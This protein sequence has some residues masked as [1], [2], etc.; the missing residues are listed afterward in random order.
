MKHSLFLLFVLS[1]L[2]PGKMFAQSQSQSQSTKLVVRAKAKDA[3]F[4]GT[5]M[6]GAM[7]VVRDTE[8]GEILAQGVTEGS[9]GDTGRLMDTPRT[10]EMMLSTPGAAKFE[11]SLA[12]QEPLMVTIQATAPY[13]QKQSHV[14]VSTQIW[15]I[16]GKDITGD[17]IIMEIP[18]FAV[19]VLQP[20][21]HEYTGKEEITVR[22]NVVMMCGCPTSPGGL[23]DSSGYEIRALIKK[24][25]E[26]IKT[27]PLG[28]TG[29]TSTYEGSFSPEGSAYEIIVYAYDPET[30]NTG[31]DKTS[32]VIRQ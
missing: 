2:I 4:I 23:W 1:L 21:A 16:P 19:D 20:Q 8:T 10:R 11:T 6:G 17:G 30:G 12:L 22:A 13:A 7:I 15:M 27:V 25:G 28:F 26:I 18:G 5:S 14:V 24:E 31:V 3:K 29:K 32:V 9:T